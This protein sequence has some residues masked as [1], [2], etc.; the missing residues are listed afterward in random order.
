M[1]IDAYMFSTL[2]LLIAALSP[3][4]VWYLHRR[5]IKSEKRQREEDNH[6][7]DMKREAE[8]IH[9]NEVAAKALEIAQ[10]LVAQSQQLN[11]D[12]A[13]RI[14][15]ITSLFPNGNLTAAMTRELN[16]CQQ[17]LSAI[18]DVV[19][20]KET[21]GIPVDANA[22]EAQRVLRAQIDYLTAELQ[23]RG[24]SQTAQAHS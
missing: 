11:E 9:R 17:A 21:G 16:Q 22:H 20:I 23:K 6:K 1:H 4:V 13:I 10:K 8:E 3:I 18:Q 15:E 5:D 19:V 14:G 24:P 12:T 7:R 2:A